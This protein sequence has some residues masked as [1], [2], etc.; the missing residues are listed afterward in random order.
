MVGKSGHLPSDSSN[1]T[2]GILWSLFAAEA[3]Q[4]SLAKEGLVDKKVLVH[5][6]LD[7]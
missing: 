2:I 1:F 7:S 6:G 4:S 3:K 5:F